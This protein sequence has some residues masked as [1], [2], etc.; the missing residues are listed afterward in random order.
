MLKDLIHEITGS[1]AFAIHGNY[2]KSGKPILANDP[3]LGNEIPCMW[4]FQ[5][6]VD[7]GPAYKRDYEFSFGATIPGLI[8]LFS[9]RNDQM[10]FGITALFSDT[11]DTFEE[12]VF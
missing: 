6:F 9:G 5:R 4:Y 11:S 2:T 8:G 3:H 12:K 7:N 10:A 1:N